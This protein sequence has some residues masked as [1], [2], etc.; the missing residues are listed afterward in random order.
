MNR[1]VESGTEFTCDLIVVGGGITGAA[2]AYE[3]ARA[4]IE[5]VLLEKRDF[6]WATSAATSKLIHGGLRYLKNLEFGLVRESLR[7]RRILEDIAPNLVFPLPFLVP[8]YGAKSRW[9]MAAGLTLY[10]LLSFDRGWTFQRSKRLPRHRSVSLS[11]L[12]RLAPLL[13]QDGLVG[14]SL[15]YDCQSLFPERLT[16]AFVKSAAAY[17]ARVANHTEVTDFLRD[18]E[19]IVGVRARDTLNGRDLIIRSRVVLNSGGPWANRILQRARVSESPPVLRM[20]EGIHIIVPRL[21]EQNALVLMTPSGRH[22]FVI[23]WRNH[24]LIGTTD[25]PY[26]GSP[27][28]YRITRRAIEAFLSEINATLRGATIRYE[29][30]VHAYGGLRPLTDTQAESTY[31]SSRR[32]EIFDSQ[33]DGFEGLITV[34]GGKYTT[35]RGLAESVLPRIAAKLGLRAAPARSA[36][37]YL[38]GCE[39]PDLTAFVAHLKERAP[40]AG[41]QLLRTLATSFGTDSRAVLELA[42]H[43][44]ALRT[45]VTEDGEIAAEALFAV[46]HEM[47]RTLEDVLLRR[48]G[49]ATLGL[50]R[51][52]ILDFVAGVVA[53]E[54]GW[55]PEKSARETAEVIQRVQLPS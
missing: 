20:S 15:Y 13:P 43:D 44:S 8:H 1:F 30:I 25:Q 21:L 36:R 17:G 51:K 26:D 16:L 41:E 33:A 29:D 45:P 32:Y 37:A 50:P 5:T 40:W 31:K 54:L 49:I 53:A 52:E 23:P 12:A 18:G 9:V 39:V 4:G 19:R 48:T 22:F 24:S 47:A 55:G 3:A 6:G 27:D 38:N 46:R 10:D 35:S 11:E 28:D 34:E 42:A 2:V 14:A 7:E